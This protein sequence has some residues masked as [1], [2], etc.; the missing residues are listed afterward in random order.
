MADTERTRLAEV[1]VA[2]ME[3]RAEALLE[4]GGHRELASEL[5]ALVA[6]YPL[7]ER[8]S[9]LLMTALYR[10]GRQAEALAVYTRTRTLLD[11]ELGIDPGPELQQLHLRI[12][13][14]DPGLTAATAVSPDAGPPAPR[15][16]PA[17]IA[18]FAGRA[19]QLCQLTALLSTA[20]GAGGTAVT[21]A[22]DG[23][24]G[25]GKSALAIHAAHQLTDAGDFPDGQ[26]YVN[27]QGATPGLDPLDSLHALGSMLRS[28]G[29]G[30]AQIPTQLDEASALFRTLTAGRR[31][32]LVLDNARD[33]AQVRPLLPASPAC[34]VLVT[35][36]QVLATLDLN[37]ARPLHLDVLP[38]DGALSCWTGSWA[39]R[40]PGPTKRLPLR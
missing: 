10:S 5:S 16:L 29:V 19:V 21:G 3:D 36:R 22:V 37:G 6:E 28:L 35:S 38:Q 12:L 27:L 31:L 26:L 30:A 40:A 14:G 24:G 4:L 15:Q 2:A 17:D 20:A 7:R 11:E 25:V 13:A 33:A 32:L 9:V 39:H 34:R 23:M 8:I 1:H 18:H